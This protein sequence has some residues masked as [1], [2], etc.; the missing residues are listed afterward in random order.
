M[1]FS[2]GRGFGAAHGAA[3]QGAGR[4]LRGGTNKKPPALMDPTRERDTH[5]ILALFRPYRLR[6]YSVMGL[7]VFGAGLSMLHPFL[8]R[9]VLDQG[10]FHHTSSLLHVLV[11]A[12]MPIAIANGALSV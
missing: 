1:S 9:A 6:L 3:G 2:D 7:I 12:M 4:V 11:L 10:I 5:R 8:L